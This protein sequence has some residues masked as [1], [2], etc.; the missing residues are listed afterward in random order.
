MNEEN[1]R[2]EN[3]RPPIEDCEPRGPEYQGQNLRVELEAVERMTSVRNVLDYVLG[4]HNEICSELLIR[5]G[6]VLTTA[7]KRLETAEVGGVTGERL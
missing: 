2:P 5:L 7:G 6:H 3:R 1:R 4:G